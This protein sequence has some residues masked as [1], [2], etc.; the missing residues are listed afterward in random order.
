MFD[1]KSAEF[2]LGLRSVFFAIILLN[3]AVQSLLG[4]RIRSTNDQTPVK[5]MA[6]TQC[7]TAHCPQFSVPT[8][9]PAPCMLL[10]S[11]CPS[12]LSRC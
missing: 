5:I 1:Q 6:H 3:M 11:R 8:D 7:Q 10:R 12:I 2:T 9:R 4:W